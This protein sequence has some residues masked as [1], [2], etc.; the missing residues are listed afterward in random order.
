MVTPSDR[1]ILPTVSFTPTPSPTALSL[2]SQRL[3]ALAALSGSLT[4]ALDPVEA[5]ELVERKAL[6][7]LDAT[8]AIVVTL[9]PFP[10]LIDLSS[11]AGVVSTLHVVHA[12]GLPAE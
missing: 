7:A 5:A 6:A 10:P 1:H 8:S 9:G 11:S 2:P 4:D 3:H 12:I